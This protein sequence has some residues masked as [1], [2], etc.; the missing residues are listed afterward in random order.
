MQYVPTSIV[1]AA[2]AYAIRPYDRRVSRGRAWAIRPDDGLAVVSYYVIKV[3]G[4]IGYRWIRIEDREG[5]TDGR[6]L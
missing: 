4:G 2:R 3:V 5:V 1:C 6:G